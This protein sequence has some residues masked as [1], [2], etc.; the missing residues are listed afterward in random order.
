[1]EDEAKHQ[2]RPSPFIKSSPCCVIKHSSPTSGEDTKPPSAVIQA[3]MTHELW[4]KAAY[5]Q[6]ST[7]RWEISSFLNEPPPFSQ[8]VVFPLSYLPEETETWPQNQLNYTLELFISILSNEGTHQ[9][10]SSKPSF[11]LNQGHFMFLCAD[12]QKMLTAEMWLC[13]FDLDNNC[14]WPGNNVNGFKIEPFLNGLLDRKS[15]V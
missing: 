13:T 3:S 6:I 4:A 7:F 8:E 5:M 11:I 12:S 2:S 10:F 9:Q 15:V 14:S 1:M